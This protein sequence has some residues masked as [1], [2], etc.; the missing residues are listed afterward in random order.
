MP[1]FLIIP[2]DGRMP[3]SRSHDRATGSARSKRLKE[4]EK[5]VRRPVEIVLAWPCIGRLATALPVHE[6]L[7]I[8]LVRR[9]TIG[10][11]VA[12]EHC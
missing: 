11:V 10:R 5:L 1:N 2:I 12:R 9:Q 3:V 6:R 8:S 7:V 4:G